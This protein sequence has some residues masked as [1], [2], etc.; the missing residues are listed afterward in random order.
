MENVNKQLEQ[1]TKVVEGYVDAEIERLE[2]LGDDDLA[3]LRKER[4]EEMKKLAEKRVEWKKHVC[5]C[6][7]ILLMIL[8]LTRRVPS[9]SLKNLLIINLVKSCRVTVS[10][11]KFR[12]KKDSLR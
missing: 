11:K 6:F 1:A 4:M 7:L 2:N 9:F 5:P 10:T 12:K 8:E 3:R